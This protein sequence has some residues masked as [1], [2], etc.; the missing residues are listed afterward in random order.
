M[1]K[2]LVTKNDLQDNYCRKTMTFTTEKGMILTQS[3][4]DFARE[5]QIKVTYASA[6]DKEHSANLANMVR[7]I[8]KEAFGMEDEQVV[9]KVME[10]ITI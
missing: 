2:K 1:A 7:T 4:L 6:V 3:A 8:L 10:K 5:Y 9:K